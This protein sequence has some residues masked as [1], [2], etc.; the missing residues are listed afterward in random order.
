MLLDAKAHQG[1]SI[2][3]ASTDPEPSD[4][5]DDKEED[6]SEINNNLA[7]PASGSVGARPR[8]AEGPASAAQKR[9]TFIP[10]KTPSR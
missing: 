5:D 10:R 6:G 3:D 8:S 1:P 4:D 7:P 9:K 2:D